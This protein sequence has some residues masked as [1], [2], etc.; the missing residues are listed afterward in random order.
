M[1]K[2]RRLAIE[3][4]EDIYKSSV[5]A[6]EALKE[7]FCAEHDLQWKHHCW[8]CQ[9]VRKDCRAYLKSREAIDPGVNACEECP[10]YKW[11]EARRTTPKNFCGCDINFDTIYQRI[12]RGDK[13]A[14]LWVL[15]ALKGE[16]IWLNTDEDV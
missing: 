5:Q 10:L 7:N 6:V 13:E 14:I 12:R 16:P 15:R 1:T 2:E 9:Y 3:M 8:F 11:Y 4:W